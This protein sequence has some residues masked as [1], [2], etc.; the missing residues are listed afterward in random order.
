MAKPLTANT[1]F[2]MCCG[3]ST[4]QAF[5][6]YQIPHSAKNRVTDDALTAVTTICCGWHTAK[7]AVSHELHSANHILPWAKSGAHDKLGSFAVCFMLTLG[8]L[9]SFA[10][11]FGSCSR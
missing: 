3:I 11:C 8:K 7:F 9:E 4:R 1:F 5:A 2:A 10:M 6:V